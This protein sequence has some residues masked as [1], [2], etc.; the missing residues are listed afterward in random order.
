MRSKTSCCNHTLFQKNLTRFAPVWVMY[1][2]CLLAGLF[3][4]YTDGGAS[5]SFSRQFAFVK[6]MAELINTMAVINMGYALLVAELLFGDLFNSRMC[7][8]LHAM[9]LQRGDWFQANV[10]SGMMFSLVPTAVMA[11]VAMP[12]LNT[13]FYVDAWQIGILWF[14]GTNLEYLCFFGLAAFSAMCVGNRFTMAA[15]YGLLNCGAYIAYWLIDTIYTPMLYGVVTPTALARKLTPMSQMVDRT[16]IETANRSQ[17]REWFGENYEGV[18][19]NF[20]VTGDWGVLV[21]WAA[22]GAGFLAAALW[23]YR[24]RDLECAGDAVAFKPLV[25]VFQV[26]CAIF[27]MT[28]GQFFLYSVLGMRD[29]NYVILAI[30][31]VVGWFIGRMLIERSTRVFRLRNWYGL[32]ALAAALVLTLVCTHFDVLNIE[33]RM[34]RQERIKSVTLETGYVSAIKL[35]EEGDIEAVLR[36]HGDA[37]ENR[38]EEGAGTYVVGSNGKWIRYID[39][40]ADLIDEENKS[41]PTRMVC[42]VELTY[43][44]ENGNLVRRD[45]NVWV[46][47]P[48]GEIVR[49]YLNRWENVIQQK[50]VLVNGMEFDRVETVL[51]NFTGFQVDEVPNEIAAAVNSR[52]E[53]ESFLAAVRADCA[54]GNMAQHDYFHTGYYRIPNANYEEGY[55]HRDRLWVYLNGDEKYGLSIEVYMDSENTLRWLDDHGLLPEGMEILEGRWDYY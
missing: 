7:N 33:E 12:L 11:L 5:A 29:R 14:V 44:L 41:Q 49:D 27:V 15:G 21:V 28:A 48:G 54:A 24:K 16:F 4:L 20:K 43:E 6:N 17:L 9:P 42:N 52:Q 31:L 53:A 25:P 22:V 13:T 38:A 37:L 3:L 1:A 47:S 39:N 23:L 8:M 50:T 32:G 45:Y 55:A 46:D 2:I 30:G 34:P 40:N 35:E 10:L 36:L 19:A 26:L 18:V 51:A